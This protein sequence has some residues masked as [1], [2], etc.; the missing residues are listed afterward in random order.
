MAYVHGSA[1]IIRN[2]SKTLTGPKFLLDKN[3]VL[4]TVNYRL[5]ILGFHSAGDAAVPW[6]FGLKEQRALKELFNGYNKIFVRNRVTIFG[7]SS[8]DESGQLLAPS[9]TY[10]EIGNI[11]QTI[12]TRRKY[13]KERL[14]FLFENVPPYS[15][16]NEVQNSSE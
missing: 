16:K 10:L 12:S 7:E 15:L 9:G 13:S 3:I 8:G 6:N 4:V 14:M 11:L 1:N 2:A 5:G